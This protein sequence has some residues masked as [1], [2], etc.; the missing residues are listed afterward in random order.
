MLNLGVIGLGVISHYYLEALKS[1]A[2]FKLHSVCDNDSS[3]L[4]NIAFD[5]VKKYSHYTDMLNNVE[6]DAVIVNVPN[7]L[8]YE[9]C[10]S[11]LKKGKNV[12]CEKPLTISLPDALEL[13]MVSKRENKTL[14]TAFHRRYNTNYLNLLNSLP[15]REKITKVVAEYKEK[16]EDHAASDSWYMNSNYCGGGCIADNGPNV[17]DTLIDLLSDLTVQDVI[18]HES[19]NNVE[20]NAEVK[21]NTIDHIPVDVLLDW[22]YAHGES[23]TITIYLDDGSVLETDMLQNYPLFKSSLYHEYQSILE[24]FYHNIKLKKGRGEAGVKATYLVDKCYKIINEQRV[25]SIK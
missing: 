24:D 4:N 8:H 6:L 12:C 15:K 16:I 9:V 21:M 11:A 5:G 19:F 13:F 18:I 14:F 20:F 10:Q 7:S 17:F 23:K 2:N 1:Q 22:N 3:K 25:A